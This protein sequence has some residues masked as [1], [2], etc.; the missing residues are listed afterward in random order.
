MHL[1]ANITK[2]I[3][4]LLPHTPKF[5]GFSIMGPFLLFFFRYYISPRSR[6]IG[7]LPQRAFR[8]PRREA[9]RQGVRPL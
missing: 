1:S 8:S 4:V 6:H 3:Y 2:S 9:A 7:A 5:A